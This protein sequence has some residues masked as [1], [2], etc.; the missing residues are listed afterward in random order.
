MQATRKIRLT[1]GAFGVIGIMYGPGSAGPPAI[2]PSLRHINFPVPAPCQH[3]YSKHSG[4]EVVVRGRIVMAMVLA[5]F[6][7][8]ESATEAHALFG[9]HKANQAL[10]PRHLKKN[11]SPYAYLNAKKQKKPNGWYRSTLSGQMVYGKQK[12][13]K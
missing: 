10:A 12:K 7:L 6:M 9:H 2:G 3:T 1:R 5:V 13:K 11:S 8:G 4:V